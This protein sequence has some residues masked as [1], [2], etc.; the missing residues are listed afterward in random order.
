[1]K[2]NLLMNRIYNVDKNN[3]VLIYVFINNVHRRMFIQKYNK[4]Y[5]QYFM[6]IIYVYLHMVKLEVVKHIQCLVMLIDKF[7]ECMF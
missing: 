2:F 5:L 4:V 1:M 6:V 7:Q 3:L